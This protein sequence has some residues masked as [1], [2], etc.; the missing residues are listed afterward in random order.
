MQTLTDLLNLTSQQLINF[1]FRNVVAVINA[2]ENSN[3]LTRDEVKQQAMSIFNKQLET[4]LVENQCS[5]SAVFKIADKISFQILIAALLRGEVWLDNKLEEMA[6]NIRSTSAPPMTYYDENECRN[7]L[8]DELYSLFQS[9]FFDFQTLIEC[10][11]F[12]CV[13]IQEIFFKDTEI[14]TLVF[15]WPQYQSGDFD[16]I[17]HSKQYL[18]IKTIEVKLRSFINRK[19]KDIVILTTSFDYYAGLIRSSVFTKQ[20]IGTANKLR[21]RIDRF[22]LVIQKFQLSILSFVD[23]SLKV[24]NE[25]LSEEFNSF[26]ELELPKRRD[27]GGLLEELVFEAAHVCSLSFYE[28]LSNRVKTI[29]SREFMKNNNGELEMENINN[30]DLE[31]FKEDDEYFIEQRNLL[32]NNIQVVRQQKILLKD[33]LEATSTEVYNYFVKHIVIITSFVNYY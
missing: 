15:Q 25:K 28:D 27:G 3:N 8:F 7:E 1:P 6:N 22:P 16:F 10:P 26:I 32:L 20:S 24:A 14:A 4:T 29:A 12:N 31:I 9:A 5:T 33:C 21:H 23:L 19:M 30:W 11:Y 2:I 13:D 17:I 18:I